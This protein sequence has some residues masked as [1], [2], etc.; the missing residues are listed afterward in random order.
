MLQDVALLVTPEQLGRVTDVEK[1]EAIRQFLATGVSTSPPRHRAS[2]EPS[3]DNE[4]F[5]SG[6]VIIFP[7]Y[8]EHR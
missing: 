1:I 3:S 8:F 6:D 7:L 5:T 2:S 4:V